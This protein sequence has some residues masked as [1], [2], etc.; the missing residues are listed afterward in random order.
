[1]NVLFPGRVVKSVRYP[2]VEVAAAAV[3]DEVA[4]E[5]TLV[6]EAAKEEAAM[7]SALWDLCAVVKA[8]RARNAVVRA[9]CM[10]NLYPSWR[11]GGGR[12]KYC[13]GV[14][15]REVTEE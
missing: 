6:E 3:E 10:L 12:S 4:V 9:L 2:G 1:L 13:G 5:R 14:Y 7:I 15:M 8:A 11:G